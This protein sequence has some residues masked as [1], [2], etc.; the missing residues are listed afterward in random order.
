MC[1]LM[2]ASLYYCIP[3]SCSSLVEGMGLVRYSLQVSDVWQ[4][5]PLGTH[6]LNIC[7]P[8]WLKVRGW[9]VEQTLQL[10]FLC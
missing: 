7:A 9:S 6:F 5:V 3:M 10:F 8:A 1:W 4:L 2:G